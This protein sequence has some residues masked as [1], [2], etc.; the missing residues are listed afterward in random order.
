MAIETE[1]P[2]EIL[3]AF[4]TYEFARN[5]KTLCGVIGLVMTAD[6]EKYVILDKKDPSKSIEA[7]F[8]VHTRDRL[9]SRV[10]RKER[11]GIAELPS[12]L[13]RTYTA[14]PWKDFRLTADELKDK[15]LSFVDAELLQ[16]V[17]EN[18][19]LGDQITLGNYP[20]LPDGKADYAGSYKFDGIKRTI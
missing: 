12:E 1:N 7:R 20:R 2:V 6:G 14:A 3:G 11:I 15:T 16:Q 19:A 5:K 13:G 17:R 9:I 8:Y 4:I 10:H 18:I